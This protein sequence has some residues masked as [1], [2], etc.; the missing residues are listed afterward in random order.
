M[1]RLT[2]FAAGAAGAA[3][4]LTAPTSAFA[5]SAGATDTATTVTTCTY[6]LQSGLATYACTDVTGDSVVV[7]GKVGMAGPP[8]PGTPWPPAPKELFTT[9]SAEIAGGTSLGSVNGRGIFQVNTL[10]FDGFTS[11]VPCGSTV[12][13]TFSVTSYGWGP[14]P[15]TVSVPVNC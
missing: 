5:A 6:G 2:R 14:R 9:L 3:A 4:L 12:N 13:A 10:R 1:N 8:S 7:Y 11:T 15:V